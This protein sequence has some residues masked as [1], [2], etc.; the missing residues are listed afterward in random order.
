M[1]LSLGK[2]LPSL[3]HL[4]QKDLLPRINGCACVLQAPNSVSLAIFCDRQFRPL[5][6]ASAVRRNSLHSLTNVEFLAERMHSSALGLRPRLSPCPLSPNSVRAS[7]RSRNGIRLDNS[8][9]PRF[10][11]QKVGGLKPRRSVRRSQTV[12]APENVEHQGGCSCR[13]R[14]RQKLRLE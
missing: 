8:R 11:L 14:V 10:G 7:E 5:T 2:S 1:C 9:A 6:N 3:G 12:S 13:N 4:N